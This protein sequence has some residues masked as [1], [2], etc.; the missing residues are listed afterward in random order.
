MLLGITNL[1]LRAK[2]FGCNVKLVLQIV[3]IVSLKASVHVKEG[4]ADV[5]RC[6]VVNAHLRPTN[7]DLTLARGV[8]N[9]PATQYSRYTY[10]NTPVNEEGVAFPD[11]RRQLE[12]MIVLPCAMRYSQTIHSRNKDNAAAGFL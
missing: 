5:D 7:S 11:S 6:R 10:G 12:F 8:H 3:G 4:R 2:A 9:Q 1:R